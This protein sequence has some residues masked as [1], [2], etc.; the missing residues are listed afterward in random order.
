MTG[1]GQP[2]AIDPPLKEMLQCRCCAINAVDY[3]ETWAQRMMYTADDDDDDD[4]IDDDDIIDD[5]S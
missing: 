3:E 1:E 2:L 4:D 5:F